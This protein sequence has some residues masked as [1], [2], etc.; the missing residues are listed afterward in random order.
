MIIRNKMTDDDDEDDGASGNFSI[1]R[2]VGMKMMM[3]I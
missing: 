2:S 3:V 1:K